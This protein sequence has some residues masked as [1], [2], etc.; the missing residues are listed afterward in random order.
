MAAFAF[1]DNVGVA[2]GGR[3]VRLDVDLAGLDFDRG[4][5]HLDRR[6]APLALG[7]G[8]ER[9]EG[10]VFVVALDGRQRSCGW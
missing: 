1:A 5:L 7:W 8:D 3:Q 4:V 10:G 9:D 6:E 2:A